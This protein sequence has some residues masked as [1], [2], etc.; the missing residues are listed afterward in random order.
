[1]SD[2]SFHLF[3]RSLGGARSGIGP[4][5]L[6]LN[7]RLVLFWLVSICL[8]LCGRSN[9]RSARATDR[10]GSVASHRHV[11]RCIFEKIG[12]TRP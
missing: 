2:D 10:P 11:T 3:P 1:M 8:D 9:L 4:Q 12:I 7:W 6:L 5:T